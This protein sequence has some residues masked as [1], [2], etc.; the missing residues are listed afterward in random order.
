MN[1]CLLQFAQS[2][3]M[4]QGLKGFTQAGI[5]LHK[6][7]PHLSLKNS[8]TG[9]KSVKKLLQ[10]VAT[11]LILSTVHANGHCYTS[12]LDTSWCTHMC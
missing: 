12:H 3:G 2:F 7:E 6:Q 9:I 11:V 1:D 5:V 10:L 8:I 4:S